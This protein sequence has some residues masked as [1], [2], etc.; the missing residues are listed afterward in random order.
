MDTKQIQQLLAIEQCGTLAAAAEKLYA[1]PSVL[2]RSMRELEQELGITLFNRTQDSVELNEAG[3]LAAEC[4]KPLAAAADDFMSRIRGYRKN[5][6]TLFIGS[7]APGPM[8]LVSSELTIRLPGKTIATEVRSS[9]ELLGGLLN[10]TYHLAI[11]D[12]PPEWENFVRRRYITERLAVSLPRDH[13]LASRKGLYLSEL[14][15]YTMLLY[16]DLGIWQRLCAE[17]MQQT[18]FIIQKEQHTLVDLAGASELPCF[19]TNLTGI[20]KPRSMGRVEIPILDPEA[21]VTF[22]LYALK[23]NRWLMDKVPPYSL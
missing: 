20:L 9:E 4:A 7:C 1:D 8:W 14:A 19:T 2:S 5:Q 21:T 18:H 15:G 10:E 3:H 22:Y 11:L 13:P 23:E 6:S 16:A 17:K 12:N